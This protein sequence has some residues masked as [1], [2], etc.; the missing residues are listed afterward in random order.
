MLIK[1]DGKFYRGGTQITEEDYT[2]ILNMI[3]NKPTAPSGYSYR[4]T[5]KLE[6]ELYE[7][8]SE[9]YDDP[10]LSDEEAFS[11]IMGAMI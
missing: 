4:L 5:E 6:W 2:N 9:S 3:R 8:P 7:S 11:I 1:H 10:E